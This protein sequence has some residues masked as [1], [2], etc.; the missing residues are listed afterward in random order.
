M[1]TYE[2]HFSQVAQTYAQH[3]PR[4]PGELFRWLA[5]IAPRRRLAWDAG[6]GSGQA[7]VELA[8]YFEQVVATDPSQD[9]LDHAFP[10]ERVEY[11]HERA[12]TASLEVGS[13]DLV[14]AAVAAHWFELDD[15]YAEV[16]RVAAP[17][18][19]IAAWT[20]H[21]HVI[22]PAID[23]ELEHV[24]DELGPFWPPRF[25]HVREAYRALPFP[26]D[27]LEAPG[28]EARVDWDLEQLLG[29]VGS[30]SAVRRRAE[31]TGQSAI[32]E[33]RRELALAWG[34]PDRVRTVRLPLALR[35]GRVT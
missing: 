16:R 14:T 24:M 12:E 32:E 34:P 27:E 31:A 17:G 23:R 20:Y 2:D 21:R 30:W 35:V 22:E 19:V 6:A 29:F 13:V 25:R 9:Q 15:F 10:H 3:R 7:A 18:C 26:F 11:R 4:H 28:F 1:T 8:R 5:S 33:L